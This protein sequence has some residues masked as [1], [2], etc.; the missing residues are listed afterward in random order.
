MRCTAARIETTA[1]TIMSEVVS[2]LLDHR[3][4]ISEGHPDLLISRIGPCLVRE[5]IEVSRGSFRV[6]PEFPWW[7]HRRK[8]FIWRSLALHQKTPPQTLPLKAPQPS[9]LTEPQLSNPDREIS[10]NASHT[11]STAHAPAIPLSS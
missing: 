4:T 1:G 10:S 2:Y 6:L 3:G 5:V 9:S 7:K 8:I 11:F